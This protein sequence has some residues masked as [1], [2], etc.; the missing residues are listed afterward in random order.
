MNH[1]D[2]NIHYYTPHSIVR[3][4]TRIRFQPIEKVFDP[5]EEVD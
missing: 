5:A 3:W 1:F 4:D 2:E